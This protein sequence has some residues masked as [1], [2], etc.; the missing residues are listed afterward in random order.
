[1]A[2][3]RQP[4]RASQDR[5]LTQRAEQQI[6]NGQD[7]SDT[8]AMLNMNDYQLNN[9][10][11]SG[12][13]GAADVIKLT[14]AA[15]TP[16]ATDSPAPPQF[17]EFKSGDRIVTMQ[18]NPATNQFDIPVSEAPRSSAST[19]INT[20]PGG[21][22]S[23][24]TTI[25][26]NGATIQ[27]MRNGDVIVKNALGEQVEGPARLDALSAGR[28]SGIVDTGD[29]AG[30]RQSATDRVKKAGVLSERVSTLREN[31]TNLGRGLDALDEGA[32]TGPFMSRLPSFRQSSVKLD[33]V[34]KSLGLDVV[35]ATTFGALSKGE[36]D[37]AMSK[38]LPTGL[39][40]P[41][42]KE[43]ITDKIAAQDKLANYLSDAASFMEGGGT[44]AEWNQTQKELRDPARPLDENEQAELLRLKATFNGQ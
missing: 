34:Q 4:D 30:A 21:Q 22:A 41:A 6:A 39:K 40:A 18:L 27:T 42:L 29:K 16:Q 7:P 13:V 24:K 31:I 44:P 10:I 26:R 43:W 19:T 33:N 1:L 38:A 35:G 5:F 28:Q 3:K 14:T 11:L 20:N 8:I 15:L 32:S 2:L 12:E 17:K 36:L 23:A 25:F 37:L 9:K